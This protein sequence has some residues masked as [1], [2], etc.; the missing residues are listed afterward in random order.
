MTNETKR[1]KRRYER[2]KL[3]L[4][5]N[6]G[7]TRQCERDARITSI[8]EGGAFIQMN[9]TLLIDQIIFLRLL[10]RTEHI[11]R[12]RVR[13]TL[14]DVGSGVEFMELTEDDRMAVQELVDNYRSPTAA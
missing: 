13:Y 9:F 4:N 1:E 14:H 8:S 3:S 12:C 5:V 2:V 6:W 10:L 7:L 11:L